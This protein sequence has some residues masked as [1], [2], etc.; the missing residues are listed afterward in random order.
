MDSLA[1]TRKLPSLP[2]LESSSSALER[3]ML[4]WFQQGTMAG[5]GLLGRAGRGR[6]PPPRPTHHQGERRPLC[7]HPLLS[8]LCCPGCCHQLTDRRLP[9]SGA[10]RGKG[11]ELQRTSSLQRPSRS[12]VLHLPTPPARP[13]SP[14][15]GLS[16]RRVKRQLKSWGNW[17]LL[18]CQRAQL[19]AAEAGPDRR[20][21]AKAVAIQ[22]PVPLSTW[23]GHALDRSLSLLPYPRAFRLTDPPAHNITKEQRLPGQGFS[24]GSQPAQGWIKWRGRDTVKPSSPYRRLAVIQTP[25]SPGYRRDLG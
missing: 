17:Q 1:R 6:Q 18:W 25:Y 10:L 5:V 23:G 14:G 20:G 21:H 19:A 4:P 22:K 9:V 8:P 15:M 3:V 11:N 7:C 2:V 24:A 12:P 13:F 16:P